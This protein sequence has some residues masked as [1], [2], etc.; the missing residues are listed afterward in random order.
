MITKIT[1]LGEKFFIYIVR[2]NFECVKY[3]DECEDDFADGCLSCGI[4]QQ[5]FAEEY[6]IK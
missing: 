5:L 1:K 3:I 4:M 2:D 6:L